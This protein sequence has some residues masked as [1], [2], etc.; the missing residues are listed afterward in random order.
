MKVAIKKVGMSLQIKEINTQ[1]R[2]EFAKSVVNAYPEYVPMQDGWLFCCVDEE[3]LLKGLPTNF[4][5]E[6]NSDKFPLQKIV[7]DVVFVRCKPVN[8]FMEEV[9]DL[10]IVDLT[11]TDIEV[12]NDLLSNDTQARLKGQFKDYGNNSFGYKLF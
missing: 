3:G 5:M 4:L 7:G 2:T 10:E 1:Y 9:Y 12:I 11:D 8:F 6:M